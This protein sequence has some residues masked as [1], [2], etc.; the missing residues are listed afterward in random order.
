MKCLQMNYIEYLKKFQGIF[1]VR[2]QMMNI[3]FLKIK[4]KVDIQKRM[5]Q[6][7]NFQKVSDN[8]RGYEFIV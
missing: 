7:K 2:C 6:F 3:E 1:I 8:L 5:L 4:Q